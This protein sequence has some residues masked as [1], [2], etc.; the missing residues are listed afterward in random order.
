M[1]FVS[2]EAE[3]I[4]AIHEGLCGLYRGAAVCRVGNWTG[5]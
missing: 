3:R 4:A 1:V 2:L 5:A